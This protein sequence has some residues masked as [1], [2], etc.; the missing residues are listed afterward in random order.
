MNNKKNRKGFTIV[1]LSIVIAVIAILAVALIPTIGGIIDKAKDTELERALEN[2]FADYVY[3]EGANADDEIIIK[4]GDDF[5]QRNSAG[6]FV[7][8]D[9]TDPTDG[10]WD[11]AADKMK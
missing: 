4:Y 11:S 2:E 5:Y 3:S 7:E 10:Y 1:E 8:Y 6:K 9:G